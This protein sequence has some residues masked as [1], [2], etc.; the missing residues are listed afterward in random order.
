MSFQ[1]VKLWNLPEVTVNDKKRPLATRFF[2]FF[3][4]PLEC[5]LGL[6]ACRLPWP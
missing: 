1:P 2:F 4:L 5:V 3:N 6:P